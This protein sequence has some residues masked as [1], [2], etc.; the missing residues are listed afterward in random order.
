M[1]K[2]GTRIKELRAKKGISQQ[3]LAERLGVS[4]PAISQIETGDRKICAEE[5]DSLAKIFNIS[6]DSLLSK[7]RGP[8]VILQRDAKERKLQPRIRIN[9]PQ[10]NMEKFKE[11][12]L[13]IL[14]KVGSKPNVGET[15]I[16]KLL[17]FVDFDFYE[18][19]EEQLIGAAYLKNHYGP[20][21]VEFEKIVEEMKGK[22]LVRVQNTYFNFPQNKYLPLRKP[23]LSKLKANE[24]ETIDNVLNKLSDMNASQISDY[25]HN[26]V[27]WLTTE[28]E[29]IIEYE[30]A[31]YRTA[32]YS[33]REYE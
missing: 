18:K 10:K 27:P 21:P 26:D 9:V 24:I 11:V 7:E 23:D 19:Y 25:S 22:D 31:F 12:L 8:E 29:E 6:V 33:V 28:D 1:A 5:L 30:S 2:I 32:P 13:Y 20:T 16:Y 15:V 4:R 3:G 14:N 17:Y